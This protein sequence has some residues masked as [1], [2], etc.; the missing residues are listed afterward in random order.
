MGKGVTGKAPCF[1][2]FWLYKKRSLLGASLCD[3]TDLKTEVASTFFFQLLLQLWSQFW[4]LLLSESV[5]L[6]CIAE[7]VCSS[8]EFCSRLLIV[9]VLREAKNQMGVNLSK[10]HNIFSVRSLLFQDLCPDILLQSSQISVERFS[11]R[12]IEHAQRYSSEDGRVGFGRIDLLQFRKLISRV[13]DGVGGQKTGAEL[14]FEP[15]E[16]M[17]FGGRTCLGLPPPL[18]KNRL[19]G[20]W[21]QRRVLMLDLSGPGQLRRNSPIQRT[22]HKGFV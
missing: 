5:N 13:F 7:G 16:V 15:V 3:M 17:L 6:H 14:S 2:S 11:R 1:L 20:V 9:S 10:P 12:Q 22:S 19:E 8:W 18:K 4:N 21:Q